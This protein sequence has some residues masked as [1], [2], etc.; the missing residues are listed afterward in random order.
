MSET[1]GALR[2]AVYE[3]QVASSAATAQGVFAAWKAVPAGLRPVAA[4]YLAPHLACGP[5]TEPW[6]A[7]LLSPESPYWVC[8]R[9]VVRLRMERDE[10][11]RSAL[12]LMAGRPAQDDLR[13]A[14][15]AQLEGA[16]PQMPCYSLSPRG[17]DQWYP[18]DYLETPGVRV[19]RN[20]RVSIDYECSRLINEGRV[21]PRLLADLRVAD[22]VTAGWL[23]AN[24]R[25][26]KTPSYPVL[27]HV[28]GTWPRL[29]DL[30]E[31]P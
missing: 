21:E 17:D 8:A 23:R 28:R 27:D 15:R 24:L 11:A 1:L 5:Q 26:A 13:A 9:E 2:G 4:D 18:D 30:I 3:W 12:L 19:F 25:D 6:R 20:C 29:A 14:L 16:A 31:A 10:D 22:E 7:A